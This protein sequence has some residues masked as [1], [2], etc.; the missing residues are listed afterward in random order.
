MSCLRANT[1]PYEFHSL[2]VQDVWAAKLWGSASV[3]HRNAVIEALNGGNGTVGNKK[4]GYSPAPRL[5]VSKFTYV[6]Y[7]HKSKLESTRS[8]WHLD[9]I[10]GPGK[11]IEIFASFPHQINLSPWTP[12]T[13]ISCLHEPKGDDHSVLRRSANEA[14]ASPLPD[15]SATSVD[16]NGALSCPIH[17]SVDLGWH[18]LIAL[19]CCRAHANIMPYTYSKVKTV[20]CDVIK[21]NNIRSNYITSNYDLKQSITSINN[22]NIPLIIFQ[23]LLWFLLASTHTQHPL[24]T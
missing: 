22:I 9:K 11:E 19:N 21:L 17:R 3:P 12:N 20:Y 2:C 7:I 14:L 15:P 18:H 8:T 23:K 4:S 6:V 5:K 16:G 10:K 13:T 1:T 24:G